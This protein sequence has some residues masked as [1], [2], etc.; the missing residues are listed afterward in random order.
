ML[1]VSTWFC[2]RVSKKEEALW[3]YHCPEARTSLSPSQCAQRGHELRSDGGSRLTA[4]LTLP[5]SMSLFPCSRNLQTNEF[6]S[7]IFSKSDALERETG[8]FLGVFLCPITVAAEGHCWPSALPLVRLL[9]KW[10][11][12]S[13]PEQLL[14]TLSRRRAIH[15][16]TAS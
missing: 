2:P 14:G 9:A 11:A 5:S 3:K 13:L 16:P 10:G 4:F 7:F 12:H 1:L 15:I 6:V 8:A